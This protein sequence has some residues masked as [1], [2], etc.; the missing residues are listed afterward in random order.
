ML[1]TGIAIVSFIIA[2]IDVLIDDNN[3]KR[4]KPRIH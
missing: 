3:G 2:Y 4:E 1:A